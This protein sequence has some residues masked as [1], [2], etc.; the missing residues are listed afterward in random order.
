MLMW[1][2]CDGKWRGLGCCGSKGCSQEICI[3][4]HSL[5]ELTVRS[6]QEG[7]IILVIFH[8][9]LFPF[10]LCLARGNNLS[11]VPQVDGFYSL[12]MGGSCSVGADPL[13]IPFNAVHGVKASPLPSF[14][15][16]GEQWP[17]G[18]ALAS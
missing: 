8:F 3:F 9:V 15:P 10:S 11:W 4:I 7:L 5:S 1:S 14:S 18:D 12:L 6:A 13:I 2:L 16:A 17:G